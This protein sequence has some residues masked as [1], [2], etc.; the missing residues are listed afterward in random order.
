VRTLLTGEFAQAIRW[1]SDYYVK[2]ETQNASGTW[3][4]VGASLGRGWVVDAR[5]SETI[6]QPV[7][8]MT[9]RLV[10]IVAGTSM[11]PLIAASPLNVDDHAAYAP[12][13]EIGRLVRVNVAT[14][15]EGVAL[16]VSKYREV[17]IGR[18]DTV[19]EADSND[20]QQPITLT[21]SDLGA[22]LMDI[23]IE[24]T[25]D[26]QYGTSTPPGTPLETV[27]QSI[28]NDN[29]PAGEPAVTLYKQSSSTFAVTPLYTQGQDK[30]LTPLV[31]LVLDTTGEDLRYR[32]DASHVSR[33]TWFN[34]DRTRSTVDGTFDANGYAVQKLDRSLDVIR[35]AGRIPSPA[36]T[37]VSN[38][39]TSLT[40]AS[41][42]DYRRHF[43]QL[44]ASP[45]LTTDAQA[46][47]IIDAAINDLCGAPIDASMLHP[48][49][50]FVQ[51]YDRYTYPANGRQY[52]SDQTLCV[53][54]FEH[55]I[56]SGKGRTTLTLTGRVVG[57]YAAWRKRIVLGNPAAGGP[58]VTV[59]LDDSDDTG[60]DVTINAQPGAG[61]TMTPQ[62]SYRLSDDTGTMG[63]WSA[64]AAAP[65][66]GRVTY[67]KKNHAVIQPRALQSDGQITE[68]AGFTL[69]GELPAIDPPTGR[70]KRTV[71]L[72]DGDYAG[73]STTDDGLTFHEQAVD[74]SQRPVRAFQSKATDTPSAQGQTAEGDTRGGRAGLPIPD[75]VI[76]A[77]HQYTS[78]GTRVL[79]DAETGQ[80]TSDLSGPTGV[81][82]DVIERGGLK[83]DTG[84]AATDGELVDTATDSGRRPVRVFTSK[85]TDTPSATG[86]TA[87]GAARVGR[88]GLPIPDGEINTTSLFAA[89][90]GTPLVDTEMQRVTADLAFP[91]GLAMDTGEDY[92]GRAGNGLDGSG[93][94][95]LSVPRAHAAANLPAIN[96]STGKLDPTQPMSGTSF[97]PMRHIEQL[98]VRD[99]GTGVFS[100]SFDNPPKI[101]GVPQVVSGQSALS[102][103]MDVRATSVTVSTFAARA[104][105]TTGGSTTSESEDFAATLGG[106]TNPSGIVINSNGGVAWSSLVDA[107][108]ALTTYHVGYDVDFSGCDGDTHITV[109]VHK[110]DGATLTLV[111]SANYFGGQVLTGESISFSDTLSSSES[112]RVLT[113]YTFATGSTTGPVTAKHV[114]FAKVTTGTDSSMT[115]PTG[116]GVLFQATE[117]V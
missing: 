29:I 24:S 80:F 116:Y 44:P 82:G 49:L 3:I 52:D 63:A 22:W 75:G 69:R 41:I 40:I 95:Q 58:T 42:A 111:G 7:S 33:L 60:A 99:T 34:P 46:L 36:G 110:W 113:T 14:M 11:S 4:D 86:Q 71:P 18:V 25:T 88:G 83:G 67:F 5:W 43:M 62:V 31:N 89:G 53:V 84:F 66:A 100:A 117:N 90:G 104:V 68:G 13:L 27:L 26:R 23:E 87:E 72:D 16:D 98:I 54:G 39:S 77:T 35:N 1:D 15:A 20:G 32:Y 92:A 78:D 28:V 114:T 70:V 47:A 12:L 8:S 10:P 102:Q 50:W 9:I 61:V 2:F 21:C 93:V 45:Q 81:T 91:G 19:D 48:F 59:S 51:L 105:W 107:N 74:S 38:T 103:V 108:T 56:T 106:T 85:A 115:T 101:V 6:D 73:T 37:Y 57:A 30:L 55:S 79:I 94:V 17:F 97:P 112:L 76:D 109:A 65:L 96:T 64:W